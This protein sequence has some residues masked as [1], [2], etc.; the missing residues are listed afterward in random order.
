M[1][2]CLRVE[3]R[4]FE[5]G[6]R[7]FLIDISNEGSDAGRPHDSTAGFIELEL[8]AAGDT[9]YP[10]NLGRRFDY[11]ALLRLDNWRAESR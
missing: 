8:D 11:G 6:V 9:E 3:G 1:R 5:Y 10:R 4:L 2:P 7:V